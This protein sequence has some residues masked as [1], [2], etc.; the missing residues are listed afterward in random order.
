MHHTIIKAVRLE[1]SAK[2]KFQKIAPAIPIKKMR[3]PPTLSAKGPF[4]NLPVA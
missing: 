2:I 4:M 1:D 3:R